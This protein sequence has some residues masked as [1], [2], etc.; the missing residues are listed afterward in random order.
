M[1]FK[2]NNSFNDSSIKRICNLVDTWFENRTGFIIQKNYISQKIGYKRWRLLKRTQLKGI[3]GKRFK[4]E[5]YIWRTYFDYSLGIMISS[6]K[7]IKDIEKSRNMLYISAEEN[8]RIRKKAHT[9]Q[10]K[11]REAK[12]TKKIESRLRDLHRGRNF[13]RELM[14]RID[15]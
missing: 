11:K 4:A 5:T 1:F 8:S 15:G 7:V 14:E 10:M 12:L 3:I 13:H 6:S 9:E 2:Y